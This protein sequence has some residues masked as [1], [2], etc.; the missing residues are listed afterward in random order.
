ML[1]NVDKN[2]LRTIV[3]L[4]LSDKYYNKLQ[5]DSLVTK[6]TLAD[7]VLNILEWDKSYNELRIHVMRHNGKMQSYIANKVIEYYKKKEKIKNKKLKV[8]K[9]KLM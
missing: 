1:T 2:R 3:R 9:W 5:Y 8:K 4:G 7:V 6:F